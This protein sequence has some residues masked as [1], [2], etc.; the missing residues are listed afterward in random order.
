[1]PALITSPEAGLACYT[2]QTFFRFSSGCRHSSGRTNTTT[3]TRGSCPGL[4]GA[5]LQGRD[6]V[7]DTSTELN[8]MRR[9]GK[10]Q[11]AVLRAPV[12]E[13]PEKTKEWLEE[14][15]WFSLSAVLSS[16]VFSVTL[17]LALLSLTP[18]PSPSRE[19]AEKVR[20]VDV[21]PYSSVEELT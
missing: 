8:F 10:P 21:S 18:N 19:A 3:L 7:P 14:S 9:D 13:N 20:L 12:T 1:V 15:C 6:G 2:A 16:S 4:D 17:W 11:G 5:K